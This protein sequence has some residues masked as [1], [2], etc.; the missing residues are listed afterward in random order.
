MEIYIRLLLDYK[1]HEKQQKDLSRESKH[2][3]RTESSC[4]MKL[5]VRGLCESQL[6]LKT[7][8]FVLL[9]F[10]SAISSAHMQSLPS[11]SKSMWYPRQ[12]GLPQAGLALW[13]WPLRE[14]D[15]LAIFII[16]TCQLPTF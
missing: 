12:S 7:V 9:T 16:N 14:T 11:V 3:L 6:H 2:S 5:S 4:K 1:L 8:K 15:I 13:V 10:L